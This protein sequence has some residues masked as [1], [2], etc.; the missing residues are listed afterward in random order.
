M[1][2]LK[3]IIQP[4]T[5]D[6]DFA[7]VLI[8]VKAGDRPYR[9]VLDTGAARSQLPADEYTSAL[10]V[11]GTDASSGAFGDRI[12]EPLVTIENLA[13]GS[14]QIAN[15]TVTRSKSGPG[16]LGMDVLG[17]HRCH[18]RLGAGILGV[19]EPSGPEPDNQLTVSR[20]GHPYVEVHWPGVTASACWDT[21]SG[22][23]IVDRGFWLSHPELFEQVGATTGTDSTGAQLQ[24]P[25]LLME[26]PHI[27]NRAFPRHKAVAVD[28]STV[29]STLDVPMDVIVGYQTICQADWLFDFPARRWTIR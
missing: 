13:I 17:Q 27:G 29:N 18:F 7:N 2:L 23:T 24:T 12:S 11:A 25:V 3:V 20:R 19:D 10:P 14:L 22:P 9:V 5:D 21:G 16:A 4:D 15:L 8:D 6:P 28:L 26:G 1:A